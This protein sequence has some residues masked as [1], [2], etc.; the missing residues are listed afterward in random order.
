MILTQEQLQEILIKVDCNNEFWIKSIEIES[1]DSILDTVVKIAR[2][3]SAGGGISQAKFK[4]FYV[5][6]TGDIQQ[7]AE[8]INERYLKVVLESDP[9]LKAQYDKNMEIIER[10]TAQ[11]KAKLLASLI[12][13]GALK[14]DEEYLPATPKVFNDEDLRSKNH[15]V[16]LKP[17]T[18]KYNT[19]NRF[20]APGEIYYAD[21][22]P[23]YEYEVGGVRPVLVLTSDAHR[24]TVLPLSGQVTI[25][26]FGRQIKITKE[27]YSELVKDS[28]ICCEV[29]KT[30][31]KARVLNRIT[32]ISASDLSQVYDSIE[33][34]LFANRVQLFDDLIEE[35]DVDTPGDKK[36][37][38]ST[39]LTSSIEGQDGN[40][41]MQDILQGIDDGILKVEDK[42]APHI[43]AKKRLQEKFVQKV[44]FALTDEEALSIAEKRINVILKRNGRFVFDSP[45]MYGDSLR[46]GLTLTYN[47]DQEAPYKFLTCFKF[48]PF[49]VSLRVGTK[50]T[51]HDD[52]ST[53]GLIDLMQKKYGHSYDVMFAVN[54]I[55]FANNAFC[56]YG[57]LDKYAE[58]LN[59]QLSLIKKCAAHPQEVI[60]EGLANFDF[61]RDLLDAER[62]PYIYDC[63]NQ[64]VE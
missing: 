20:F 8:A 43:P 64:D 62:K 18:N 53:I 6:L 29:V 25:D 7:F 12:K 34:Q 16:F 59:R 33:N 51:A 32:Q 57:N 35:T 54:A 36:A 58:R 15:E 40:L 48:L 31:S 9:I 5:E 55:K 37:A 17:V 3:E 11:F 13:D 30:I 50:F 14:T 52:L 2:R 24:V 47:E 46:T 27:K 60:Q 21:L 1:P 26:D 19:P 39:G 4:K 23:V 56:R 63:T 28:V 61:D 22:N 44:E 42:E 45:L 10:Q 38:S 41:T 49:N